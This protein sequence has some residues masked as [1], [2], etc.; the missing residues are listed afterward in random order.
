MNNRLVEETIAEETI[1][2]CPLCQHDEFFIS[3]DKEK[4]YCAKCG[5]H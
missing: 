5:S 4:F 1:D 3:A 2:C